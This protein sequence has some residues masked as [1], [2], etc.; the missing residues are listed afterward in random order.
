MSISAAFA[1]AA[2]AAGNTKVAL[3]TPVPDVDH[4]VGLVHPKVVVSKEGFFIR[5]VLAAT[6]ISSVII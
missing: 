1:E 3:L 4:L 6:F 2:P 5:L